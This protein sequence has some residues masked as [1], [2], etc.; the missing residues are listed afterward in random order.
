MIDLSVCWSIDEMIDSCV[1]GCMYLCSDVNVTGI[2]VGGK[3][4]LLC[5]EHLLPTNKQT[6]KQTS[7]QTHSGRKTQ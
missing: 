1:D 6:S 7:K 2:T 5:M 4:L 3:V